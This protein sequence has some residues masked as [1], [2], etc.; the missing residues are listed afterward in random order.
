MCHGCWQQGFAL[1]DSGVLLLL[2][3]PVSDK[4]CLD[5][6]HC[7]SVDHVRSRCR[8]AFPHAPRRQTTT[9][10]HTSLARLIAPENLPEEQLNAVEEACHRA[11]ERV[12]GKRVRFDTVWFV[13]EAISL[14]CM[15]T[16]T[17]LPL[18]QGQTRNLHVA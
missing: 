4:A 9:I 6:G 12:R 15:G 5:R 17:P 18:S 16:I 13:E 2:Y 7:G 3:T 8:E 1:A 14:A 10:I 11:A